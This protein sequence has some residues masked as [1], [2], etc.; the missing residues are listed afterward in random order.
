MTSNLPPWPNEHERQKY[1]KF[2]K[3]GYEHCQHSLRR[4]VDYDAAV[5]D[6]ELDCFFESH[7]ARISYIR[8]DKFNLK[9]K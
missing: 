8:D 7:S 6:E 5:F 1:L 9:S 3:R 4:I 2:G